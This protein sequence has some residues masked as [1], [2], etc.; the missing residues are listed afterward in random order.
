MEYASTGSKAGHSDF[1]RSELLRE[2]ALRRQREQP[3]SARA[4]WN[5][6]RG[7]IGAAA[8][9]QADGG[10]LVQTVAQLVSFQD[11]LDDTLLNCETIAQFDDVWLVR[12]EV[13]EEIMQRRKTITENLRQAMPPVPQ[14]TKPGDVAA[15]TQSLSQFATVLADKNDSVLILVATTPAENADPDLS[16]IIASENG[17]REMVHATIEHE[18]DSVRAF[19]QQLLEGKLPPLEPT[20]SDRAQQHT[21]GQCEERH[22]RLAELADAIATSDLDNRWFEQELAAHLGKPSK[23]AAIIAGC[24]RGAAQC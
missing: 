14:T 1:H 5:V 12:Q 18:K 6:L 22:L 23:H 21:I 16:T 11:A 2:A 10:Q 8:A 20:E 3:G 9:T 15:A 7:T 13:E 19:R 17:L 4:T 24:G